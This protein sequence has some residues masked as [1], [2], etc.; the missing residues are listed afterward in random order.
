MARMDT[1]PR[2]HT[3]RCSV[4]SVDS[5]RNYARH[6]PEDTVLYQI[7][8]QHLGSF[9]DSLSEQGAS[10]PGFVREEFDA[11]LPCA[12]LEHSFVRAKCEGCREPST[13]SHSVASSEG[14]VPHAG[15]AGWSRAQPIWLTTCCLEFPCT[16][17]W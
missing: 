17:G 8:E 14:S 9:F 16:N 2:H 12:R 11:Y 3:E 4:A 5:K 1:N 7:V 10:L 13:W 15:C 6:H